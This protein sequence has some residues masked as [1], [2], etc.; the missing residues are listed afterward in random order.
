MSADDQVKVGYKRPPLSQQFK[1]GRSGNP[2][3]RPKGTRNFKT[4]LVDICSERVTIRENGKPRRM[5]R[6][7]AL[8]L[9][10]LQQA[11][12]GDVKAGAT[13]MSILLQHSGPS[14]S[15]GPAAVLA[16][17]DLNIIKAFLAK[18]LAQPKDRSR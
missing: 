8:V 17:E 9:G 7:G 12:K 13:I 18:D 10:T 1:R 4:D 3:G 16:P 6:Q 11:M 15:S 14:A 2:R 5:T